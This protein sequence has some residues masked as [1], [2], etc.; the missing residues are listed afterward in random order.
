[1]S[2]LYLH[3]SEADA[4]RAIDPS[5]MER[6]VDEAVWQARS[7]QLHALRLASCGQYV[8]ARLAR[9]D[10]AVAV[11]NKAKAARK[12]AETSADLRQAGGDLLYAVREMKQRLEEEERETEFFR[13]DDESFPPSSLT[14]SLR[15]RVGYRWR[16]TTDG[17][18]THGCIVFSHDVDER[19]DHT[20]S[21]PR[22]KPPRWKM[23]EERQETLYGIWDRFRWSA[24]Q[25]VQEY[26]RS[27]RDRSAIPANFRATTDP[28]SRS[29]GRYST[30]FWRER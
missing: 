7:G 13:V 11:H 12:R 23:E 4:L 17:A 29:L 1:M 14:D 2:G 26:L 15:V 3:R 10:Q 30:D 20:A 9:F 6:V 25:S 18:W 19:P 16:D 27:G 24:L 21:V 28:H 5:E 8:S 22:R